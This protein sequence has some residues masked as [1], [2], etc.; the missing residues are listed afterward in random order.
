MDLTNFYENGLVLDK[1]L[2]FGSGKDIS[3]AINQMNDDGLAISFIDTSGEVIRCMVKASVNTRPD[4]SNEK[5]GWYVYNENGNYI[6]I[7]Y[8]NWRNGTT[9][10]WSNTDTN[11]LSLQERNQLKTDIANNIER[12]KK[13]RAK[14]HDEVAK[15]CEERFK[16]AKECVHHKYLEN[17][18]IKNY[19]LKTI[20]DSLVVPLYSTNSVKDQK[21]RSLQYISA[22]GEKRFVSASEVKGS[23]FI[24][25][26]SWSEWQDLEKVIVVE[27]ISTMFSIYEATKIPCV[28]TFSANFGLTALKSLRKFTK[29]QFIIC[30]DNDSN[31]VGNM[32]SEEIASALNNCLV[33]LPSIIGDYNDLHQQQGLDAVRNEI[34]DSGLPLK[35]FNI[36]FLKGEIPKREWLVENFI[37]LGKP[38]IMASIGGIGKSMLALDLCL[39][40]AHG[41]GSWLGNQI[42]NSGSA[43][44]LSAEDDAQELHRRVDSLDKEGKRFEG[45]NEVYALPIPSMKE[46][47]IVLGDNS[48]SGLHLTSQ[49]EELITALES[50]EN[51]KLVVIDPVQSFVSASISSSNEAGQMYASF[52]ANISARLG[53]TTLSIHHMSKAGLVSTEDN[54]TA[55]ASIRGASSLVDA[56]R[57]ALALYL[58]SEEEAE[59]L[60]LQNGVEF[61]R[62]RVVRASMVKS[63]SEIDYSVKTLFRKDV[64]LETVE[65]QKG[66]INWD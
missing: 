61:D 16:S 18:K 58:S 48:S 47:L 56:H 32:K 49:A 19:G 33:R 9:F 21:L 65:D 44:Y 38:G 52:C 29:A 36:K 53:A 23:V 26:F 45:L 2:H 1:E 5:S 59:R 62:T 30:Y 51:L 31:N 64:V 4:K 39:K 57:F 55:R 24:L 41:S 15:D 37:E 14:R 60:C 25:G 7:V 40:V 42:V 8:G 22:K 66:V 63:N 50:I 11:K 3:D 54:M 6:N 10:K 43:V 13:E 27:G 34:L 12:S 28:C 17:K 20:R 35:Q 46:R